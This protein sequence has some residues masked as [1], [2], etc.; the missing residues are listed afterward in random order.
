[1]LKL[2]NSLL[3][4]SRI[5]AGRTQATYVP[6]DLAAYTAELA[7]VFRSA[8]EAAGLR[9]EVDCPPLPEPLFVDRSMWEK[10]VLNL[11]SNAFKFT[12]AGTITARLGWRDGSAVL[13]V[14]DTGTGIPPEHVPRLFERFHRVPNA[15]GRTFEGTGIG[16]ALVSELIKI[17]CGTI[18]VDSELGRGTSF[19]ITIPAGRAHLPA[20]QVRSQA[21][22]VASAAL[23]ARSFLEEALHWLPETPESGTADLPAGEKSAD[24]PRIL[25]ADDNG[26]M[27]EYVQRLLAPHWEV[28]A[29]ADG[30]QALE[31]ARERVPDLVLTD[32]MMPNLDGFGLLQARRDDERTRGT[33]I[34]M[35]SARAGEEARVEGV[36]AGADDYLVKPFSAREL[37]ARVRTNLELAAER[38]KLADTL[39]AMNEELESRVIERTTE[40]TQASDALLRSNMDLQHF[41]HATAHDLRTP[42]RSIAGFAQLLQQKVLEYEDA[43][44]K[45]WASMVIDNAKRLQALIDSLLS[46]TRTQTQRLPIEPVDLQSVATEVITSLVVLIHETGAEISCGHLP[47]LPADRIQMAQLLQNLIENGIQ[48]NRSKP[49]RVSITC[50]LLEGEWVF[51]VK[52]NGIG[53]DPKHHERI[54]HLF[55]RLHNYHQIPGSGI[56]LA[57]CCRIVERHGGRIW[58][59]SRL[60][61]GSTFY[62]SLPTDGKSASTG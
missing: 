42:L 55:G 28:E 35:L 38:R 6:T 50:E 24:R 4:F 54:F 29:V 11:L 53:I 36:E 31:A 41:A 12:F 57:L 25:L 59:K 47:T 43:Q 34:I 22:G 49:P 13:T 48:Y 17:H 61:E 30:L 20:G 19:T 27:R 32:V 33:P 56:G 60:G 9:L 15:Q 46:Y 51:S 3:D 58:V 1:M 16:L 14:A 2:V 7:S 62:F 26:D 23:G 5:E 37:L 44:A 8:I 39:R 18:V 52:D 40:L 21:S 45:E 10:I